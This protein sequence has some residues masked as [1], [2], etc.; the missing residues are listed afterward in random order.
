MTDDF[1]NEIQPRRRASDTDWG[2]L[3][4]RVDEID[5]ALGDNIE[6]TQQ[7]KQD[8]TELVDAFRNLQGFFRVLDYVG[9]LAKPLGWIFAAGTAVVLFW[10][11]FKAGLAAIFRG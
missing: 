9:K 1:G 2:A 3:C 11:R 5:R 10:D 4:E 7:I 6:A 8:T